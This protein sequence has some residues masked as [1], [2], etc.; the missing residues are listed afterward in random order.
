MFEF[1]FQ[2]ADYDE[3]GTSAPR[4]WP[5]VGTSSGEFPVLPASFTYM[6]SKGTGIR[7][8]YS[9][10]ALPQALPQGF[11]L[12]KK[13]IWVFSPEKDQWY[14]QE[15]G[16]PPV[17]KAMTREE[18]SAR[19]KRQERVEGDTVLHICD[20]GL[21]CG[22]NTRITRSMSRDEEDSTAEDTTK[23]ARMRHTRRHLDSSNPPLHEDCILT[24]KTS[25][26]NAVLGSSRIEQKGDMVVWNIPNYEIISEL[27][28]LSDV[29]Q[30]RSITSPVFTIP[31][32]YRFRLKLFGFGAGKSRGTHISVYVQMVSTSGAGKQVVYPFRGVITFVVIDQSTNGQH[33][34]TSI[35]AS[36]GNPSFQKP[37]TEVN[38]ENGVEML[39]PLESLRAPDP[40][41]D[42]DSKAL[43]LNDTLILGVSI[44]YN[45]LVA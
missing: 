45:E 35:K 7:T 3:G 14:R 5:G 26:L 1:L 37:R 32:G 8:R 34:S 30:F 17:K 44:R 10:G 22:Q 42:S 36:G 41:G 16:L 13:W 31:G 28:R 15:L 18:F 19:R 9:G 4:Y 6:D 2:M 29:K 27:N 39:A 12:P 25:Y 20:G 33:A 24:Q 40:L 23:A 11:N 43:V 21:C 38:P